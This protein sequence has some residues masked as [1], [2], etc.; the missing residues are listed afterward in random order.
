MC[1]EV[2]VSK[3]EIYEVKLMFVKKSQC[4]KGVVFGEV[5]GDMCIGKQVYGG[6]RKFGQRNICRF[7]NMWEEKFLQVGILFVKKGL[8]CVDRR[9]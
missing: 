2:C 5:Y 8:S 9:F 7:G 6:K 4:R 1:R 3:V